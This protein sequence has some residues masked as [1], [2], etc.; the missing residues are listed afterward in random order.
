MTPIPRPGPDEYDPYYAGYVADVPPGDVVTL[1]GTQTA[2]LVT[3]LR[4]VPPE[5]E[6]HRY[7]PDK[8]SIREVV[9]HLCDTERVLAYRALRFSRGDHT[10]LPGFEQDDYVREAG[11]ETRTLADLTDE[12]LAIRR[13]TVALFRGMSGAMTARHGTAN[14]VGVSVRALAYIIAGHERHHARVL[15]ERYG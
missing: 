7:A 1:L 4:A 6:S 9:G 12:F 8:W 13:A 5:R 10:P 14:D 15:R 3:W 2:E 11:C